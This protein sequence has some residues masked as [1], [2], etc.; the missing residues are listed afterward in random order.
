MPIV[1]FIQPAE[2][3]GT[4]R[5]KIGRSSKN[6]L[7]RM[8]GYKIGSRYLSIM[9]CEDDVKVEKVLISTFNEHYEKVAGNEYFRGDEEDML[10][11]FVKT[12]RQQKID[13]VEMSTAEKKL[14][15]MEKYKFNLI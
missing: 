2:L 14:N 15:W 12:V 3:V 9:E 4:D 1:Y 7:S 10:E 11:V 13:Q 5:Y 6:D 8:K